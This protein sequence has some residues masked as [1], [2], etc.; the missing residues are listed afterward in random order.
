MKS[1]TPRIL[2]LS[3]L[4]LAVLCSA[5]GSEEP[6]EDKFNQLFQIETLE[7]EK[8]GVMLE[9]IRISTDGTDS[10][11]PILILEGRIPSEC[12]NLMMRVDEPTFTKQIKV[13]LLATDSSDAS[14]DEN[15]KPFT[16]CKPLEDLVSGTYTVIVNDMALYTFNYMN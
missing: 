10:G 11:D 12:G 14:P 2:I 1:L 8:C 5:C 15:S 16:V 7:G 4:C 9:D 13:I 3:L 6:D